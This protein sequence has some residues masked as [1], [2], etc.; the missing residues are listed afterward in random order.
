[1]ATVSTRIPSRQRPRAGDRSATSVGEPS[2]AE[3]QTQIATLTQRQTEMEALIQRLSQPQAPIAPPVL[4]IESGALHSEGAAHMNTTDA[5]E[6]AFPPTTTSRR[7]LLKWGGLGAAAVLAAAGIAGLGHATAQAANGDALI[8]GQN[9]TASSTT[10]LTTTAST[11]V[12]VN[13]SA[14]DNSTALYGLGGTN[15]IGAYGITGGAAG[16]GVFGFCAPGYGVVGFSS[17]G[18]DIWASGAG[19]FLQNLSGF[20]GAPTTGSYNVGE[21]IRDNAGDLYICVA[22]GSPGTWR[23]VA[24]G[25]PGHSGSFNFLPEPI[26][27]LDTRTGSP[28][29]AGSTHTLQVTGVVVDGIS[30]PTG[31]VGVVGNVTVVG[32][33][34]SG[35]LRL[36]PGP[37]LPPTSSIN[38]AAGQTL[39]NGVTVRFNGSGQIEF[40]VDMASG[41]TTNVLFDA[42]G[43][44]L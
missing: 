12:S 43:Y 26:R 8:L 16:Y 19:R 7:G 18:I 21:Q 20:T 29:T 23:R 33:T 27:L 30:V 10:L 35:D 14:T 4:G 25:T 3:L 31:S 37:A 15:G 2:I 40:Q 11:G 34:S 28:W 39:A 36:F 5:N 22:S 6:A 42:V 1:M 38:F 32:P 9:N 24:A 44:I 41:A 17:T 13:A